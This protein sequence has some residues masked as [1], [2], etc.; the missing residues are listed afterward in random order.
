LILRKYL[1]RSCFM[2]VTKKENHLNETMECNT[3][4]QNFLNTFDK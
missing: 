1:S 3:G 4:W 2:K